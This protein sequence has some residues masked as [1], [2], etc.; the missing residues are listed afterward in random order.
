MSSLVSAWIDALALRCADPEAPPQVTL[1]F[2]QSL[3]GSIAAV[4]GQP[5]ALSSAETMVITHRLRAMHAAIVVGVGTLVAD[6][7]SL[8]TRL[9]EGPSPRPVVLDASLRTPLGQ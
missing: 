4:R 7:P 2:A 9:V 3:D 6:D 5:L 8:T 1:T